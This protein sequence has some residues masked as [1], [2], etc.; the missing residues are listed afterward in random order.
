MAGTGGCGV[1]LESAE[2]GWERSERAAPAAASGGLVRSLLQ[3][4][5]GRRRRILVNLRY[6][7]KMAMIGTIGMGFLVGL[8]ILILYRINAQ[9]SRELLEVAPFLKESLAVRDRNQLL[10]MLAG[11]IVFMAG[12]F[13]VEILES[14][15]TAGVIHNVRRR[16]EEVRSGRFS[17]RVKLRKHDNFPELA[18]SFNDM[19]SVIRSRTEGDLATLGRMA[20]LAADL[21]REEV[22]GNREGLRQIAHTLRQ[23]LEDARRHKSELLR[24]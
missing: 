5:F 6:Q 18:E 8:M 9:N 24:P 22:R 16:L 20:S 23:S 14:H 17:A 12:V 19:V 7:L 1:K 2:R 15:K 21:L 10:V 3:K 13:L 4:V 11:G